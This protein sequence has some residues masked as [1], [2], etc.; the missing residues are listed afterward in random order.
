MLICDLHCTGAL[1]TLL[2]CE[3]ANAQVLKS[4]YHM[5][6]RSHAHRPAFR[7]CHAK[8]AYDIIDLHKETE[9]K[10]RQPET[11]LGTMTIYDNIRLC[12][13]SNV[14]AP[15]RHSYNNWHGV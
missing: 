6:V 1:A 10:A 8:L 14:A 13:L 4:F 11:K 5:C 9:E 12:L 3:D 2:S 7:K 15:R